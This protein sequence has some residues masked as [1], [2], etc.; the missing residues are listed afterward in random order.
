M[1]DPA[2]KAQTREQRR[3]TRLAVWGKLT[4]VD[5]AKRA[6]ME[7][8]AAKHPA[9]AKIKAEAIAEFKKV[10]PGNKKADKDLTADDL[11]TALIAG[12]KKKVAK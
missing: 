12:S 11:V 8:E 5:H 7:L 1:T 2:N 10:N 4:P 3:A 9:L 6:Y